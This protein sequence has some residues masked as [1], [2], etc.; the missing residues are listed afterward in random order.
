MGNSALLPADQQIPRKQEFKHFWLNLD[1]A[2]GLLN[3]YLDKTC[4]CQQM[5]HCAYDT[6]CASTLRYV[7]CL[8]SSCVPPRKTLVK[9]L[10]QKYS[11]SYDLHLPWMI[12]H[13][14][15]S[16][17]VSSCTF[18]RPYSSMTDNLSPF[19]L[20][21]GVKGGKVYLNPISPAGILLL[22]CG[23]T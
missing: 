2:K 11:V 6:V 9:I 10:G 3:R 5:Y 8:H 22:I 13:T 1:G 14:C 17:N 16:S 15:T 21:G 4:R 12:R 19:G 23:Q 18:E 20:I 7:S